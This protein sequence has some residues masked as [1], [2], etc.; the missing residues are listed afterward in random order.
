MPTN[1]QQSNYGFYQKAG[2]T[3]GIDAWL[4]AGQPYI[5]TMPINPPTTAVVTPAPSTITTPQV[6]GGS[7]PPLPLAAYGQL[8]LQQYKAPSSKLDDYATDNKHYDIAAYL[9]NNKNDTATLKTAGFQDADIQAAQDFNQKYQVRQDALD[10]LATYK[11]LN[12]YDID[13]YLKDN[14][15]DTKT[16]FNAG[17]ADSDITKATANYLL[18]SNQNDAIDKLSNYKNTDGTYS[19]DNYFTDHPGETALVK[20]AGFDADAIKSAQDFVSNNTRLPDGSYMA[21]TDLATVKQQSPDLYKTLTSQGYSDYRKQVDQMNA[22][23][24]A[25]KDTGIQQPMTQDTITQTYLGMPAGTPPKDFNGFTLT[26]LIDPNDPSKGVA[27]N[28]ITPSGAKGTVYFKDFDAASAY[29]QKYS[30]KTPMDKFNQLI[31]PITGK[32]NAT[33]AETSMAGAMVAVGKIEQGS[34]ELPPPIKAPALTAILAAVGVILTVAGAEIIIRNFKASN[35]QEMTA[36]DTGNIVLANSATGKTVPLSSLV[37]IQATANPATKGSVVIA[38][39]TSKNT[40]TFTRVMI[41]DTKVFEEK[42]GAKPPAT[43]INEGF[44]HLTDAERNALKPPPTKA[45]ESPLNKP[46]VFKYLSPADTSPLQGGSINWKEPVVIIETDGAP[47]VVPKSALDSRSALQ[48]WVENGKIMIAETKATA[49]KALPHT[50]VLDWDKVLTDAGNRLMVAKDKDWDAVLNEA[51]NSLDN[52]AIVKAKVRKALA[53]HKVQ[54]NAYMS[55]VQAYAN[56]RSATSIKEWT[57][58]RVQELTKPAELTQSQT[59]T[60]VKQQTKTLPLTKV[61]EQTRV[62]ELTKPAELTRTAEQEKEAEQTKPAEATK[63]AEATRT[64]AATK[65][66]ELTKPAE[67]T[68]TTENTLAKP[69]YRIA[70]K[71][72]EQEGQK[73]AAQPNFAGAVAWRMGE[74][75]GKDVFR[76]KTQPYDDGK[77]ITTVGAV[78]PRVTVIR[79]PGSA[80]ATIQL[81]SGEAPK[82]PAILRGGG[83]GSLGAFDAEI[84]PEGNRKVSIRFAEEAEHRST[85]RKQSTFKSRGKPRIKDLGAG[86]VEESYRG[87]RRRHLRL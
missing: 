24:A 13:A 82:H 10:K 7:I 87:Q 17:F 41:P 14:P 84:K 44:T 27:A 42:P 69:R 70:S 55:A 19:L 40:G 48:Q 67:L 18:R 34:Q 68:K 76:I 66:A 86:V 64:A 71:K 52:S 74:L 63:T 47:L 73:K 35:G 49:V 65:T 25:P 61:L 43:M 36:K 50:K 11:N 60:R 20:A 28:Y 39:P 8:A 38:T 3:L 21:N 58:P 5:S 9:R 2:G 59:Q 29:E 53:A 72:K 57:S 31:S 6:T 37:K 79:G 45:I 33:V 30:A 78:P 80:K 4:A 51:V 26:K 83:K 54:V 56:V 16:L 75:H 15:K 81:I 32:I 62:S 22:K 46:T 23:V 12:G 77:L 85:Q 1:I